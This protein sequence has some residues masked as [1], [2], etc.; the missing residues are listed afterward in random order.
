MAALPKSLHNYPSLRLL[1]RVYKATARSLTPDLDR[2]ELALM[3]DAFLGGARTVLLM[4]DHE[5]EHRGPASASATIRRLNRQ[6]M[7]IVAAKQRKEH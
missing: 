1:W 7:K 4:L 6:T 3:H 5:L 2:H